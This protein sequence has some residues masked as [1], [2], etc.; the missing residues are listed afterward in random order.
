LLPIGDS[1][2]FSP[3]ALLWQSTRMLASISTDID[4]EDVRLIVNIEKDRDH[5]LTAVHLAS[6]D[7]GAYG[8]VCRIYSV[9]CVRSLPCRA[10]VEAF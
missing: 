8:G 1:F 4:R 7:G 9:P 2:L 6:G 3:S 10:A 5:A